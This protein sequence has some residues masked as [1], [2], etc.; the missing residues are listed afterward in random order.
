MPGTT[1]TRTGP[2]R[3]AVG[4][5]ADFARF[6]EHETHDL[7]LALEAEGLPREL[8]GWNHLMRIA[9]DAGELAQRYNGYTTADD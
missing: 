7:V 9:A 1:Y 6:V 5:M 4:R 2:A 3:D 8:G